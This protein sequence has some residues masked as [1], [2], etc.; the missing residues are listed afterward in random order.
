MKILKKIGLISKSELIDNLNYCRTINKRL[1]EHREV[2][3]ALERNAPDFFKE[4]EWHINHLAIQD[5][6]LMR[7]FYMVHGFF[8]DNPEKVEEYRKS[9]NRY[10]NPFSVRPRPKILGKCDL[11]EYNKNNGV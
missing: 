9:K 3:E 2:V 1:D 11:P 10:G 8:P 4:F 7:L 5:D 6:F